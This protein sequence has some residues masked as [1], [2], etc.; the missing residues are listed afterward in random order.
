MDK[1]FG[2][3]EEINHDVVSCGLR[4]NG[5]KFYIDFPID[6]IDEDYLNIGQCFHVN[7]DNGNICSDIE[8][9]HFR[10]L[11]GENFDKVMDIADKLLKIW[12]KLDEDSLK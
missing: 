4:K 7:V 5:H 9:T 12:E 10:E 2:F 1:Y 3:I 8:W 6:K 11:D